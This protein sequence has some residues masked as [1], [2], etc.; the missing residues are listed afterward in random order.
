MPIHLRGGVDGATIHFDDVLLRFYLVAMHHD[1]L[2]LLVDA[3][4]T[5]DELLLRRT[6]LLAGA[7]I[8]VLVLLCDDARGIERL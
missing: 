3:E 5:L 1:L 8:E 4:G 2:H 6:L 7:D